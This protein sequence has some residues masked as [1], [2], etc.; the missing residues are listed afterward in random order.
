[1]ISDVDPVFLAMRC[2]LSERPHVTDFGPEELGTL[3]FFHG[4]L[5]HVPPAWKVAAAMEVLDVE[6]GAA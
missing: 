2:L 6:R 5:E 3:L 1:M 4:W